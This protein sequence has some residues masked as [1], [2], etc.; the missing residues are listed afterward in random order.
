M[1]RVMRRAISAIL[2]S[3]FGCGGGSGERPLR[4]TPNERTARSPPD[5]AANPACD[6]DKSALTV[7]LVTGQTVATPTGIEVTFVTSGHDD[8]EHD[9]FDDWVSLRFHHDGAVE[10]RMVSLLAPRRAER[11]FEGCWQ[12][13]G[14][15]AGVLEIVF[16][17]KR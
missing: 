1:L 15:R 4:N 8:F 11:L 14:L 16:L 5:A 3:C 2:L 17:P 9:R 12:L 6:L 10:D 13:V 7:K